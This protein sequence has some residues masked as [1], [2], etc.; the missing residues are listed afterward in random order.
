MNQNALFL[1]I[2]RL[3]Q[4][5]VISGPIPS[6]IGRLGMLK[7]LDMSDNQL[8]GTIP[9]SLG[10]LKNLNY[11]YDSYFNLD[12]QHSR[13]SLWFR[14]GSF[15]ALLLLPGSWTIIA[16][17]EFCLIHLP[18][19]MVLLSCMLCNPILLFFCLPYFSTDSLELASVIEIFRLTISVAHYPR[20]LQEPLCKFFFSIL[21][22][23]MI[24][25]WTLHVMPELQFA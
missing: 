20:F 22:D 16:C 3:L 15:L 4:N 7:T 1:L 21:M 8:T 6:T 25:A 24:S 2:D 5:N 10:K 13:W 14:F 12:L 18:A 19:L 9:S 23:E 17:L 11:L